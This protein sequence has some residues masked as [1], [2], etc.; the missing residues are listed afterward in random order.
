[1]SSN[2][3][4]FVLDFMEMIFRRRTRQCVNHNEELIQIIR[5]GRSDIAQMRMDYS[6][7]AV[8]GFGSAKRVNTTPF[9]LAGVLTTVG[10]I[11]LYFL[12]MGMNKFILGQVFKVLKSW[13]PSDFPGFY[14]DQGKT[15]RGGVSEF[16]MFFK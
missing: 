4:S 10:G 1:M 3:R 11:E 6:Q 15:A 14:S 7:F 2:L 8:S 5:D 9:T 12:R 13:L 16:S